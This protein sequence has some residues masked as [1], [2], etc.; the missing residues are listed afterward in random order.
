MFV[1]SVED[2]IAAKFKKITTYTNSENKTICKLCLL[3]RDGDVISTFIGEA[4]LNPSDTYDEKIGNRLAE[5]R[6]ATKAHKFILQ[7][8]KHR[9][10]VSSKETNSMES[11]IAKET[12]KINNI[13]Q[14]IQQMQEVNNA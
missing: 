11:I 6:A 14:S 5:L 3:D 4:R 10:D 2:L 7:L 12:E 13:A 1:G 9:Y 8:A